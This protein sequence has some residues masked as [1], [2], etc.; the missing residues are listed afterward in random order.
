MNELDDSLSLSRANA[1]IF[2]GNGCA[3]KKASFAPVIAQLKSDFN[4]VSSAITLKSSR[5]HS[6]QHSVEYIRRQNL[7]KN[8]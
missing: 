4:R 2:S 3:A 7:K 5:L 8:G 1:T 6:D